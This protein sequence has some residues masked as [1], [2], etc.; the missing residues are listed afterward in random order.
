[1]SEQYVSVRTEVLCIHLR[2]VGEILGSDRANPA[3][4]LPRRGG[5]V[6]SDDLVLS[7]ETEALV[8]RDRIEV[9]IQPHRA[10]PR[11]AEGRQRGLDVPLFE[12]S[13]PRAFHNL[14]RRSS[15]SGSSHSWYP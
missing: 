6:P 12:S 8:E 4:P 7:L 14:T 15:S 9:C 3:D 2:Q 5:A 11:G 1:P 10:D 13:D